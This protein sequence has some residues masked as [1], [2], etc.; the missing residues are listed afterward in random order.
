M[1]Q[2]SDKLLYQMIQFDMIFIIFHNIE[3]HA[4]YFSDKVL[5]MVNMSHYLFKNDIL[6]IQKQL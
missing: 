1:N 6:K 5:V 4:K 2:R 3:L